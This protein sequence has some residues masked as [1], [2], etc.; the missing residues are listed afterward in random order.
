[1][2]KS[3]II[4]RL[5]EDVPGQPSEE[6]LKEDFYLHRFVLLFDREGYSPAFFEEMYFTHRIACIT[7]NKHPGEDWPQD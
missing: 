4:P 3:E 6:D 7:Y 2:L 1:M 5:L